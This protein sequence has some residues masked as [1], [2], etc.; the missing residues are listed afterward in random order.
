MAYLSLSARC[1]KSSALEK[2]TEQL[3]A[4]VAPNTTR[5]DAAFAITLTSL[6]D[7]VFAFSEIRSG[8]H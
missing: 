8:H 6:S 4:N 2:Q 1:L 5:N 7:I 3:N